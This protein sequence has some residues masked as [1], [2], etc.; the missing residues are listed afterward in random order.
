MD[1]KIVDRIFIILFFGALW[2]LSEVVLGGYL[3][4]ANVKFASVPLTIIAIAILSFSRIY[5]S[6]PGAATLIAAFALVYKF[7]NEPFFACHMLGILMLG[8]CYDLCFSYTRIKST[9]VK[10]GVAT[11]AG[12]VIFAIMITCVFRYQPWIEGG[13]AKI[14]AY[15]FVSGTI[16]AVGA[17]VV[18]PLAMILAQRVHQA[19]YQNLVILHRVACCAI[20]LFGLGAFSASF[21]S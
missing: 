6:K 3:Y 13:F 11:Y 10:S 1:K 19:R 2:G 4:A 9:S 17:A 18:S 21:L 5:I 12:Y 7:L 15:I 8:I 14:A 20:W 16:S